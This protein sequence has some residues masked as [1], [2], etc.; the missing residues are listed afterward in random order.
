MTIRTTPVLIGLATAV[1][2]ACGGGGEKDL[3][4]SARDYYAKREYKSA[5]LQLKSALQKN[6]QSGE[7]RY[8]LGK[9]LLELGDLTAATVEL[10]KAQDLKYDADLV[11]PVLAQ[12]L[13]RQGESRQIVSSYTAVQLS[14]AQATADLKVVLATAHMALGDKA[15]AD[16]ELNEAAR[17]VPGHPGAKLL[18]ARI[19]ASKNE[20]PR[21]QALVDEVIAKDP[22]SAD[23]HVLKGELLLVAQK[24]RKAALEAFRKAI[25]IKP[26]HLG[27]HVA[28]VTTLFAENDAE[29]A[30]KQVAEMKKRFAN[31]PRTR[32]FE[33]EIAFAAKDYK[34]AR[35]HIRPVVQ[36]YPNNALALQVAGAAEYRLGALQQAE[37]YLAK[38]LQLNAELPIARR[39]LAQLYLRTGQPQR[40]LTTLQPMLEK[41]PGVATLQLAAEAH[42]QSGDS[43]RAEE[44]FQRAS[45]IKPDDPRIRT[46]LAL[47]EY[48][49]GKTD[50]AI[51]ELESIAASDKGALAEL[52]LVAAHLRKKEVDKALK[53]I[54]G[55][56]KKMPDK[57]V[58]AM[59]R[60]RVLAIKKDFE[61][62]RKSFEKSL[63][64][65][66]L[67]FPAAAG[68]AA[69][70]LA[71]Q[72]AEEAR[73]HFDKIIAADPGNSAAKQALATLLVRSGNTG[74]E[75]AKLLT[76]VVKANPS[77][78]RAQLTLI[79][80]Y[81]SRGDAKLALTA[82]R[83]ASTALVDHPEI[84]M[85]LGRT[86]LAAN[87]QQ[88]AI[89]TFNRLSTLQPKSPM[90]HLGLADAHMA[91][92][93]RTSAARSLKRALE[94]EPR[95]V[96]AQRGLVNI[97]LADKQPSVAME[98]ARAVQKQH[99]NEAVG[100]VLEG[101]VE[102]SRKNFT[103]AL[104]AYQTGLKKNNP[105]EAATRTHG[106][107]IAA[108][109]AAEAEKF[110]QRWVADH[111]NDPLFSFYLADRALAAKDYALAESRYREVIRLQPNNALA[112]NNV[113]WLMVQQNKPGAVP[114]AEKANQLLPGRPAIMDTLAGALATEKQL[115]KAIE[116][117]KAA[118][119][120]APE[121]GLLRMN[122]AKL[123]IQG[124]QKA[125]ARQE[126]ER[127]EKMGRSKYANQEEVAKLLKSL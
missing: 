52:A 96:H 27:A 115:P 91:L 120:R 38:A 23:A 127:L 22:S 53:V 54:D 104:A 28:A 25:E 3:M 114:F 37:T 24:D 100:W 62:A 63:Q 44:F 14:T 116:I 73:K 79:N 1:L 87:D 76:E 8:L 74:D 86:Y 35:E 84:L 10:R 92:K 2:M 19:A 58:A 88:Q 72:K 18:S 47:S 126:L 64:I 90:P 33:A 108:G 36:A 43:K 89:T 99:P 78:V 117:Q 102:A 16:D 69:L 7:A 124:E 12:A 49:K 5:V 56:E 93:D 83:E 71:G 46:A 50:S 97:A 40:A 94:L 118:V 101:D 30:T 6:A 20:L 107:M 31:H 34:A 105:N 39:M 15:R 55:L 9:S 68:L 57:P 65:D 80:F 60:G 32:M 41:N 119:E 17:L 45:K 112:I 125:L 4:A 123:Y 61:G 59:L 106:A 113:A 77:D 98:T 103:T 121:E 42:L 70:D 67:Y 11:V 109:Q 110:A 82:A 75:V 21:A 95:L 26:D 122:L 81:G 48:S 13:L 111:P 66:P 85:I 29:G 51:H